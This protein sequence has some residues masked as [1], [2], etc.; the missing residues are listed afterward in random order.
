MRKNINFILLSCIIAMMGIAVSSSR[1]AAQQAKVPDFIS[2]PSTS[3]VFIIVQNLPMRGVDGFVVYRAKKGAGDFSKLN[4]VPV[5][6]IRDIEKAKE[7]IGATATAGIFK[8]TTGN[9]VDAFYA[10]YE[11]SPSKYTLLG[12]FSLDLNIILGRLYVDRDVEP[13]AT[14]EYKVA[15]TDASGKETKTFGP[16]EIAVQPPTIAT[17]A[18]FAL[19]A[20]DGSVTLSW[21]KPGD[22]F[23]GIGWNI[24]RGTSRDGQFAKMNRKVLSRLGETKYHDGLL[25][26]G[27]SYF[28]Y[29]AGTDIVGNES[30]PTNILEAA[31]KD[32]TPPTPPANLVVKLKEKKAFLTW[33]MNL[34]PDM[35]AYDVFRGPE[36][37]G[38]NFDKINKAPIAPDVT[39]YLDDTVEEGLRYFYYV[40]ATDKFGNQSTGS[41]TISLQ[42]PD[43]TP[44]GAPTLIAVKPKEKSILVSWKGNTEKDLLGYYLYR[45]DTPDQM[46]KI[47]QSVI[48]AN[49]LEFEDHGVVSAEKYYYALV[50]VDASLNESPRSQV[51]A[52]TATDTIPPDPPMNLFA[53]AADRRVELSWPKGF[54]RDLSGYRAYRAEVQEGQ[55]EVFTRVGKDFYATATTWTDDKVINGTVYRYYLTAFDQAGNES[56]PSVHVI[57]KPR[58]DVPPE[59][60][61]EVKGEPAENSIM[62]TWAANKEDDIAGYRVWRSEIRTGVY[63]TVSVD[64]PLVPTATSFKDATAVASQTFWY[65]VTAIDTSDNESPRSA[66]AGPC[67]V[68][69]PEAEAAKPQPGSK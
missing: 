63:K 31:P 58:D 10:D 52:A 44:P 56:Q 57:A 26:N 2:I 3:S 39:E 11:K 22:S 21:E 67:T 41:V 47:N 16:V 29:I 28:Y 5:T 45:G 6:A 35:A 48:E 20:K 25:E 54:E 13:G 9:P 43:T 49:V 27:R 24:Y 7:I 34:E 40:T 36:M 1:A 65:R 14:Y 4:S 33:D 69:P 23:T 51:I 61:V 32:M 46:Q 18:G 66:P 60:P 50:A 42:P 15:L 19:E 8:D 59:A 55:K 30:A 64:K 68:K 17:P 12:L 38:K 37:N 62:L 53:Q